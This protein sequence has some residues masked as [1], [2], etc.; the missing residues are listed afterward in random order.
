MQPSNSPTGTPPDGPPIQ[1]P[2]AAAPPPTKPAPVAVAAPA[3]AKPA[4]A[5]VPA[6]PATPSAPKAPAPAKIVT[7]AAIGADDEDTQLLD[8]PAEIAELKKIDIFTDIPDSVLQ[9]YPGTVARRRYRPGEVLCTE[10]EGGTTAF[11]VVD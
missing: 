1:P 3:A 7:V 2:G 6:A 8:D 10:G 9:M 5:A 4:G 11:Y